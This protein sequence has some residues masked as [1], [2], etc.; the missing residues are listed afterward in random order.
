M[1]KLTKSTHQIKPPNPTQMFFAEIVTESKLTHAKIVEELDKR[2]NQTLTEA[3]ISQY[4][5]GHATVSKKRLLELAKLVK[6]LGWKNS[7][8]EMLLLE[9][10][11][12]QNSEL[13]VEASKDIL[14][15]VD[16]SSTRS[17]KTKIDALEKSI[18]GLVQSEFDTATIVGL[19]IFLTQK[20][21]PPNQ[22]SGGGFVNPAWMNQ[23]LGGDGSDNSGMRWLQ[24]KFLT[25]DETEPYLQA[26]VNDTKDAV[27]FKPSHA[28]KSS[29]KKSA[30]LK[31]DKKSP[32]NTRTLPNKK[33]S[34]LQ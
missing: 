23:V 6:A 28:A 9:D 17:R 15:T 12:I 14:R 18:D 34:P 33:T 31:A 27:K 7:V 19:V 11:F 25:L 3:K 24:W 2:A 30:K 20:L 29:T 5:N 1:K 26:Q 8:A 22:W 32:A 10:F 21:T 16:K 4:L 13:S